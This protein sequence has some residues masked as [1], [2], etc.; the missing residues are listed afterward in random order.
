MK[1]ETRT[2]ILL[3]NHATICAVLVTPH[4]PVR[5][6][7]STNRNASTAFLAIHTQNIRIFCHL[8]R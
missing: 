6:H 7:N 3:S 1:G 5:L 4:A 8:S 2:R